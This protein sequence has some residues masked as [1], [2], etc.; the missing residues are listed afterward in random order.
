MPGFKKSIFASLLL[1][2]AS[3][4]FANSVSLAGDEG[5]T[6]LRWK[7]GVVRVA[8]SS[9]LLRENWNIKRDSDVAGA[10]KRSIDAWSA[11][12]NIEIQETN[13]DKQNAS[14]AGPAGDGV[15][16]I[17]VAGTAENALLFAKDPE[18]AAATTRVFYNKRGMITEADIVLNPYLQFST[19]GTIG[20][21]DLESTLTHEIG[22]LLG[23][24]HSSVLGSTMHA[25]Y[26]KN[27]VFGLQ[28]FTS[29]TLSA[30]DI[31]AVRALYGSKSDDAE[32]C[33][34]IEGNIS[35]G[36]KAARSYDIWIEDSSGRVKGSTKSSDGDFR[37]SGLSAGKYRVF[38]QDN[39]LLKTVVPARLIG[40]ATVTAGE[41]A[42]VSAKA[43]VG[44]RD[45][46][47]DYLGFNGQLS[48]VA[49][50][51]SPGRTY[52]IY[53]G[54]KNLDP[55]KLAVSFS[56]SYLSVIPG[57]M[58]ALDYGEDL[59]VVSLEVRVSQR[60]PKGEYTVFAES[61]RGGKRAIIGGLTIDD[62]TNPWNSF[63]TFP[64]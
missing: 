12:A 33:G 16:L 61:D 52:V 5:V 55:K 28:N 37:F 31:A 2:A 6:N 47:L 63:A 48:E 39:F 20:T 42:T 18:N 1:A 30:D 36:T 54:G 3:A 8:I 15:S 24:P 21:F 56:S 51:L 43:G 25:N 46:E 13:S 17:T 19:D 57:S 49:V 11:V 40:D 62:F 44:T 26:G 23:L 9:S 60:T 14:P 27:G 58:R 32:C 38:A 50:S 4:A 59:S 35:T 41:T 7:A 22:H 29:R 45:L 10:I 34:S 53:L 64:E